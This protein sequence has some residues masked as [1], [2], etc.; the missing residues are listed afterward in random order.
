[1]CE[2]V[3]LLA[4][5]AGMLLVLA[6]GLFS[7]FPHVD[8]PVCSLE[9]LLPPR[10]DLAF[11]SERS[12]MHGLT[13]A[14][15]T[16]EGVVRLN[17]LK[18]R[19]GHEGVFVPHLSTDADSKAALFTQGFLGEMRSHLTGPFLSSFYV[20]PG[21]LSMKKIHEHLGARKEAALLKEPEP[22][23]LSES[24]STIVVNIIVGLLMVT[25]G[26]CL[27]WFVLQ[28]HQIFLAI[29]LSLLLVLFAALVVTLE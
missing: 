13:R 10:F 14:K 4:L 11:L 28:Q 15:E 6:A 19:N 17:L 7:F 3:W 23:A 8:W 2:H 16:Q 18:E 26:G 5:G 9:H 27:D 21:Q 22:A 1:M 24:G 12:A 25:T 20:V 29:V